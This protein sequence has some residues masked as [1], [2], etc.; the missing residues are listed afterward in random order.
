MILAPDA[1]VPQRDLLV[2]PVAVASRLGPILGSEGPVRIEACERVRV[3][4]RIGES[5]RVVHR[6]RVQG[7]WY[8]IS[9]RTFGNGGSTGVY[10]RAL[11]VA[12]GCGP[13]RPVVH[14]EGLETVFWTFPNDRKISQLGILT[15]DLAPLENIVGQRL[16]GTRVVA[17]APEKIV[18]LQ[19]LGPDSRVAAY[20]KVYAGD[21]G[22]RSYTVHV[23][24]A[25][26]LA[27]TSDDLRIPKP[28]AYSA[29]H[30]TLALEPM[31]G[32]CLADLDGPAWMAASRRLGV[33]LATFHTAHGVDAPPSPHPGLTR[34][35]HAARLLGRIRPDLARLAGGLA[36]DLVSHLILPQEALVCLHGDVNFRNWLVDG[37]SVG[38]LDLDLVSAGPA[39]ADLGSMLSGLRY[40]HRIG[41]ISRMVERR[42]ASAI[43]TG[44]ASVRALPAAS[45]VRWYTAAALLSERAF[46]AV[47]WMRS[48]ALPHLAA[49]LTDA[50]VIVTGE[51]DVWD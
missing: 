8:I 19:C 26:S 34:M 7:N 48:E 2:D 37:A 41:R 49:L 47:T 6:V 17:Y 50:R 16:N 44:Y 27:G 32:R 29:A 21:A 51:R 22:A 12:V 28:I 36:R 5:L 23:S 1:H 15:G 14:D 42:S 20:A 9:G 30:R 31:D 4:Y 24:L 3:K 38:L 45:A 43:L 25:H 18:T 39:A 11:D 35:E 13:L 40:Y 33:A 10:R 46:R